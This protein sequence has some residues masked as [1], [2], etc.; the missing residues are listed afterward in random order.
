MTVQ[1]LVPEALD[2]ELEALLARLQQPGRTLKPFSDEV[3]DFCNAFSKRIFSDPEA[4]RYPELQSLAFWMRKSEVT[5]MR[6]E[7]QTADRPPVRLVPRGLAFH[8]PPTNVDTISIYSLLLA[9][10]TGNRNIVR[11]S[12]RAAEQSHILVRLLNA[13]LSEASPTLRDNIVVIT[14]GRD[15]AINSAISSACDVRIIWGGDATVNSLRSV[16]MSP[17]GRDISFPDRY[18]LCAIGAAQYLRSDEKARNELAKRFFNDIFWF[19]QMACSSP[20]VIA[21]CG[22]PEPVA[23]ASSDFYRRVG[24]YIVA[25]GIVAEPA[26]RISKFTFACRAVLDRPVDLYSNYGNELSVIGLEALSGLSREH[27]G[28]GLVYHLCLSHLGELV[29]FVQRRDQTLTHFGFAYE[30]LD[31]FA[32]ELNGRGIDRMVPIGE[33]L[34]FRRHWDGM[35][36]FQELTRAVYLDAGASAV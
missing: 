30:Q 10:L 25:R 36:L 28:G 11:L 1:Q 24:E 29:P 2:V 6:A 9:L 12:P 19:D 18:A 8:I 35:D 15:T 7:F 27:S 13:S 31:Q 34:S 17:H 33:A 20:H 26:T 3:V 4:K 32:Q 5:R 21:W 14:Y 22:P 23:D 16:P